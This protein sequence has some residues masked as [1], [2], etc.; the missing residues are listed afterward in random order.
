MV[1]KENDLMSETILKLNSQL[2][3]DYTNSINQSS[4]FIAK[5]AEHYDLDIKTPK[6][7]KL[8]HIYYNK[9]EI[10]SM[11][12]LKPSTTGRVAFQLCRDKFRLENFLSQMGI[13]TLESK[14]FYEDQKKDAFNFIKSRNENKFVLKPLNLAGGTGIELNVDENNFSDSWNNSIKI[15]KRNRVSQPS[16][17]IQPFIKGFDVRVSIIEGRFSAAVLRLPA[18]IVGNGKDSINDLIKRKN[19][20]RLKIKYFNNKSI[21]INEKLKS[22]LVK[23]NYTLH[24]ILPNDEI[25]VLT[26]ISNLTLG[27]ESIDITDIVSDKIKET[28]IKATAAIPGLYTAGIDFMTDNFM[29]SEGYIIEMNTNANHTIHHMPLKGKIQEPFNMLLE[30]FLVKHKIEYG[31]ELNQQEYNVLTVICNF[32]RLKNHYASVIFKQSSF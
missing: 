22:R 32:N 15:Q 13:L 9:H 10:A 25:L 3:N 16:C 20:E 18:H 2:V 30:S 29:N 24:T 7:K 19:T 27:G 26:D 31:I 23:S 14:I 17:I 28:A 11:N 21:K 5:A 1:T 8:K 12:G 6:S 4:G